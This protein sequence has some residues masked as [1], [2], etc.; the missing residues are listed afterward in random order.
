[1]NAE[2]R[3]AGLAQARA[4]LAAQPFSAMLGAEVAALSAEGV[5]LRL[6]VSG[7]LLQQHG[8]VH[9]G[10]VAYL[11]DNALAFAGGLRLQGRIVTAE[12]KINY[13]RPA[14][15]EALV[16]RG[17]AV[18]AGRIQAVARCEVFAVADGAERLCAA[19]QGTVVAAG[20]PPEPGRGAAARA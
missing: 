15:G 19:A 16:A 11:A 12:M 1:V 5:E 2:G 18:S 10:V 20:T 13:V 14:T 8:F 9:G 3:D 6:P 17:R 7:A 4:V